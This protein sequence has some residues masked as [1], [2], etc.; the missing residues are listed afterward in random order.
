MRTKTKIALFGLLAFSAMAFGQ[1]ITR[2]AVVDL[3]K[4]I[5]AY[6]KDAQS[7][8]D[9]EQKKAQVQAEIDKMSAD[10]MRLMAQKADADKGGDSVSSLKYRDEIGKR[11][12]ALTD[13]V[14]AK[15]TE[16]DA[17]AKKLA[18]TDLFS[19]ELY[20]QIQ[21]VAQTEGYSLVLNLKSGDSVM[22]SVL[23]YSPMIDI[24]ADVIQA[25][26]NKTSP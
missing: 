22:N 1:Q 15:Q 24:T 16:L 9:F 8:K 4:V 25:L 23:W 13:F 20:R 11:S 18:A 17:D 14:S 19:Q 12:K 21:N 10:I 5:A 6:S 2:I 7:V 26:S 3:S